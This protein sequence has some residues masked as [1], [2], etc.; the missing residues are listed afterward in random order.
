M[1][2]KKNIPNT[3][4]IEVLNDFHVF[5]NIAVR[6]FFPSQS[7]NRT[8]WKTNGDVAAASV[9]RTSTYVAVAMLDPFNCRNSS[10]D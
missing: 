5:L 1:I 8:S 4:F 7:A 6:I 9:S 2:E 3:A 10:F